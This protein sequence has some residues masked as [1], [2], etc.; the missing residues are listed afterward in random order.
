MPAARPSREAS[1][2]LRTMAKG[3]WPRSYVIPSLMLSLTA[4]GFLA[5]HVIDPARKI[6][7]WAV[8]L[9]VVAFLP[10]LRTVFESITFPGGASVK[11]LRRVE[12]EQE[13]QAEEIEAIRFLLARYLTKSE[14]EL[15]K[16][17]AS[18]Y[19]VPINSDD[20]TLLKRAESLH[21]AGM[22]AGH[23]DFLALRKQGLSTINELFNL[24]ESG[25]RYLDLIAKLPADVDDTAI[26]PTRPG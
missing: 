5:W 3:E 11:W 1:G 18:G 2:T 4:V 26:D 21:R 19:P 16:Q 14:R 12:T 17:L 10:W 6:D 22:I 15:L 9:L 25:Q 7:G 13:R 23:T 20:S 8:T 24:T